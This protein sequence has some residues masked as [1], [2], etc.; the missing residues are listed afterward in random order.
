MDM[1]DLITMVDH[2]SVL[3]KEIKRE[4]YVPTPLFPAAFCMLILCFG[5]TLLRRTIYGTYV[6]TEWRKHQMPTSM[7]DQY[8]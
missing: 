3:K 6:R 1:R 8:V 5:F 2:I 4:L 7:R